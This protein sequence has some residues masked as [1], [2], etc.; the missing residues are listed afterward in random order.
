[1][2]YDTGEKHLVEIDH[3]P[4][5]EV[6]DEKFDSIT[7]LMTANAVMYGSTVTSLVAGLPILGDLDIAVS[8]QEY[9]KLTRR[10]AG[11]VKW[12]QT[13]GPTVTESVGKRVDSLGF[14]PPSRYGSISV[15]R[16]VSFKGVNDSRIQIIA[17]KATTGNLLED[18]ISIVRKVDFVFCGMALDKYGR[19]LETVPH[20]YDDC[21]N[22]LIRINKLSHNISAKQLNS[23]I[24]KYISRS[25]NLTLSIDQAMSNLE[26]I[27][28]KHAALAAAKAKRRKHSARHSI[29]GM[30]LTRSLSGDMVIGISHALSRIM[31]DREPVTG[32][33]SK[34]AQ[35]L[36]NVSMKYS[37][38]A[39][40]EITCRVRPPVFLTHDQ[41]KALM[42]DVSVYISERYG[43]G[44]K[45]V[46][47]VE[48]KLRRS[49]RRKLWPKKTTYDY[50]AA[51]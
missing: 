39:N 45:L 21:V 9:P 23:R 48:H 17:A 50:L 49:S 51:R 18:A 40:G 3:P 46:K 42:W 29:S 27:K 37:K 13:D 38:N 19:M 2:L 1:M 12:L 32:I 25:W 41:I 14:R 35:K 30:T 36:Y 47:E 24:H 26:I 44:A 6:I 5:L 4:F 15:D 7:T 31:S 43:V 33:I 8:N 28:R 10:L 22:K 34:S 20:A 16:I 11:S